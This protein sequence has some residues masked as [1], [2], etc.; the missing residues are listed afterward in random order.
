MRR[1]A[2]N[3]LPYLGIVIVAMAGTWG[4]MHTVRQHADPIGSCG[5]T[6][7]I[8]SRIDCY[9]TEFNAL[10]FDGAPTQPATRAQFVAAALDGI[11]SIAAHDTKLQA[12]CHPAMHTVGRQEGARMAG[13]HERPIFPPNP[14]RLCTAG[15]VHGLVEGFAAE[16]SSS[17]SSSALFTQACSGAG[18]AKTGCAH[19]LGHA[20]VRAKHDPLTGLKRCASIP[21]KYNSDCLNGV[22]M[23]MAIGTPLMS[24]DQ[25]TKM[26]AA[27]PAAGRSACAY[28]LPNNGQLNNVG[29][30]TTLTQCE[31]LSTNLA[32]TCVES[33]GRIAGPDQAALCEQTTTAANR[34]SCL[35]GVFALPIN[36]GYLTLD[37]ARE[38]CS[39]LHGPTQTTCNTLV[40]AVARGRAGLSHE[41]PAEQMM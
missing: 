15:Y 28:Y 16:S 26:C 3:W 35:V 27:Q 14:T 6:A 13:A 32:S 24:A 2:L 19:G 41:A 33:L 11:E 38:T 37:Q 17:A 29:P 5:R 1:F 23:E 7:N 31:S 18:T 8:T 25:Y 4:V 40:T 39:G 36:S 10:L 34:T 30:S 21:T 22:Y 9:S 12:A 20:F